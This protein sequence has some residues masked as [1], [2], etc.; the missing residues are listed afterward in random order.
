MQGLNLGCASVVDVVRSIDGRAMNTSPVV[1][2]AWLE[3]S[4][5]R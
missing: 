4:Q 3:D 2:Q 5:R 1:A